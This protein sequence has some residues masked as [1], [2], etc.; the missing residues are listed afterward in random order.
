MQILINQ[1]HFSWKVHAESV[2]CLRSKST[3]AL[4][5]IGN[6]KHFSECEQEQGTWAAGKTSQIFCSFVSKSLSYFKKQNIV[7]ASPGPRLGA[8]NSPGE[9]VGHFQELCLHFGARVQGSG[10]QALTRGS[11]A[12]LMPSCFPSNATS[13]T[14]DLLRKIYVQENGYVLTSQ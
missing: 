11:T 9:T 14:S 8:V 13:S 3:P 1:M 2:T 4:D 12:A 5:K 10:M 6:G 7:W